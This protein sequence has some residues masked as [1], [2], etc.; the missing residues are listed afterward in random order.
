MCI[1]TAE[2]IELIHYRSGLTDGQV[3]VAV[4]EV[5]IEV[6]VARVLLGI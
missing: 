3:D 4:S 6:S 2:T 1:A 5:V